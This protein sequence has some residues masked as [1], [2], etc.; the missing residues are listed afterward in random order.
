MTEKQQSKSHP[1]KKKP[2]PDGFGAEFYQTSEVE[3]IPIQLKLLYKIETE[4]ALPNSFLWG[5]HDHDSKTTQRLNK[6][7]KI[8]D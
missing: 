4:G 3:P 6:N 2:G 1:T 5:D 7:N 8:I